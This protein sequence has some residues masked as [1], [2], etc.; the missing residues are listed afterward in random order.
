[1][2]FELKHPTTFSRQQIQISRSSGRV[3]I[4]LWTLPTDEGFREPY[5]T[6]SCNIDEVPLEEGE[7]IVKNYSENTGLDQLS[8]YPES[9]FVDTGK[10][11]RIG[12]N[13]FPVWR[14]P[15]EQEQE[16]L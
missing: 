16:A 13:V 14:L 6:L 7:F 10:I 15:T 8:R 2:R 3:A 11:V 1:M 4:Q 12:M 9:G 5:A